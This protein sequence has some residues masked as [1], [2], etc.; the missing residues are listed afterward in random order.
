[1]DNVENQMDTKTNPRNIPQEQLPFPLT[2]YA[3]ETG[4]PRSGGYWPGFGWE[5]TCCDVAIGTDSPDALQWCHDQGF[6][7]TESQTFFNIPLRRYCAQMVTD[8]SGREGARAP[9]CARLLAKL[10]YPA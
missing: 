2:S 3:D 10:G 6:I 9:K 7:T 5:G 4:A 8:K 1:M